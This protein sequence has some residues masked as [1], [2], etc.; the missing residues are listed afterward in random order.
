VSKRRLLGDE[1]LSMKPSRK[2]KTTPK[3][4]V[5]MKQLEMAVYL[6]LW[7]LLSH[8]SQRSPRPELHRS[9]TAHRSLAWV[10]FVVVVLSVQAIANVVVDTVVAL[11]RELLV[12][13]V[14][15]MGAVSRAEEAGLVDER[16][17]R[18]K[19]VVEAAVVR[20]RLGMPL[21]RRLFLRCSTT[22]KQRHNHSD[23]C[24]LNASKISKAHLLSV[25]GS[26]KERVW[27]W[28]IKILLHEWN[29]DCSFESYRS[30]LNTFSLHRPRR[31]E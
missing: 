9:T 31:L 26:L 11:D 16:V 10:H 20:T 5:I 17:V 27:K 4:G 8:Q 13:V 24:V 1:L 3:A 21:R 18:F 19:D 25:L 29:Y 28:M 23:Q 7:H 30:S 14:R 2:L 22:G 15:W 12:D 6:F